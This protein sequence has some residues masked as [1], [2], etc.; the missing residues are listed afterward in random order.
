[1]ILTVVG[2]LWVVGLAPDALAGESTHFQFRFVCNETTEGCEM[3]FDDNVKQP[4]WVDRTAVLTDADI[5]RVKAVTRKVPATPEDH[6]KAFIDDDDPTI[7]Y[8]DDT[9]LLIMFTDTGTEQLARI[10]GDNVDRRLAV[11]FDKELLIAPLIRAAITSGQLEI[12]T[13]G[14]GEQLVA[15]ADA[16]K[17]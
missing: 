5:A 16:F 12:T 3:F 17:K 2:F 7:E 14:A 9:R 13:P 6:Q 11:V 15:I 1:M 4:I 8:R 10:T